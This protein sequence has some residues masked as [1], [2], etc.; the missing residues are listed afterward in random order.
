MAW[1]GYVRAEQAVAEQAEDVREVGAHPG[2]E[3]VRLTESGLPTP[4]QT[5]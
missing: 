1:G 4:A 2:P 5:V 3:R